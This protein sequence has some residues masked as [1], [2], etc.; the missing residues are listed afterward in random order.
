V[1][2][3]DTGAKYVTCLYFVTTV[4]T[5]VGFGACMQGSE[6]EKE[7]VEMEDQDRVEKEEEDEEKRKRSIPAKSL[8]YTQATSTLRT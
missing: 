6:R 1:H 5:T 8:F 3:Q 2:A 4:F 7:G